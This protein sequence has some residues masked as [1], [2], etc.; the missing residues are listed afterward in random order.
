MWQ[1]FFI[2]ILCLASFISAMAQAV[3]SGVVKTTE[4]NSVDFAS[5]VASPANAPKTI[6]ASAFTDEN[7]FFQMS[8]NSD[9]DRDR[10]SV[11]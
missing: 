11:V 1:R 7:G 9:C 3:I 5:V 4:G 8:V 10:K 2:T 6:L